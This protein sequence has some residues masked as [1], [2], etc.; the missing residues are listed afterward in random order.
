MCKMGAARGT[1]EGKKSA[2]RGRERGREEE[3]TRCGIGGGGRWSAWDTVCNTRARGCTRFAWPRGS[4]SR[5]KAA[6]APPHW[7]NCATFML[8][9]SFSS[10]FITCNA[11]AFFPEH[12]CIMCVCR[13]LAATWRVWVCYAFS[14]G[15]RATA[16]T[17]NT[18]R[19]MINVKIY[20][21]D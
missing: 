7:T 14:C 5:A 18:E 19:D 1:K 3:D 4:L 2:A 21:I 16:R 6:G 9:D 11:C 8:V 15:K 10:S 17:R 12:V 13:C 20:C